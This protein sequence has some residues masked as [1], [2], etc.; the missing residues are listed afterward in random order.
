MKTLTYVF[1]F[2]FIKY[3]LKKLILGIIFFFLAYFGI[4]D[5]KILRPAIGQQ[6]YEITQQ[7]SIEAINSELGQERLLR[8][9]L[10]NTGVKPLHIKISAQ[11]KGDPIEHKIGSTF[12]VYSVSADPRDISIQATK[13]YQNLLILNV[14]EI[15]AGL[16][17]DIYFSDKGKNENYFNGL[18]IEIDS[19][20]K[21]NLYM[22]DKN[23]SPFK[24]MLIRFSKL[25][26]I[27]L[28]TSAISIMLFGIISNAIRD[29]SEITP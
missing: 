18:T 12:K 16:G 2:I 4:E 22:H 19:L 7:V 6:D 17:L 23:V 29:H 28:S 25:F 3:F 15:P 11:S 9:R 20:D 26:L 24:L 21:D 1:A 8:Y 13:P 27:C 10:S 5:L 14:K